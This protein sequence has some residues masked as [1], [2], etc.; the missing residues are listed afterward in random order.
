M[1]KNIY[2]CTEEEFEFHIENNQSF[3]GK[4]NY[5]LNLISTN[6]KFKNLK[7]FKQLRKKYTNK[8]TNSFI[9]KYLELFSNL[10]EINHSRIWWC[11]EHVSRNRFTSKLPYIVA[12]YVEIINAIE[13][14]S[15]DNIIILVCDTNEQKKIKNLIFKKSG[16]SKEARKIYYN[17]KN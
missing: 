11:N 8:I 6:K 13:N 7:G 5:L 3:K 17:I 1:N 10:S 15:Y 14:I 2:I 9:N 4:R 16:L 12:S